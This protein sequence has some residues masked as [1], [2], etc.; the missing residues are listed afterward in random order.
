MANFTLS[1]PS[2][3]DAS[4]KIGLQNASAD[5]KSFLLAIVHHLPDPVAGEAV[6]VSVRSDEK[7]VT[8]GAYVGHA[9]AKAA[10]TSAEK[11]ARLSAEKAEEKADAKEAA[12]A[13]AEAASHKR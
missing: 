8:A 7:S 4:H 1:S 9:P 13:K 11:A 6:H 12:D 2:R 10:E 3:A 5:V